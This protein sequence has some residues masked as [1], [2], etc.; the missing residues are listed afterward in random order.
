MS[1]EHGE[2]RPQIT[3][4][5]EDGT[6]F[7]YFAYCGRDYSPGETGWVLVLSGTPTPIDPQA[8]SALQVVE[9][10]ESMGVDTARDSVGF[11]TEQMVRAVEAGEVAPCRHDGEPDAPARLG[12][13]RRELATV[14]DRDV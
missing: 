4:L 6:R 5:G 9:D 13:L 1:D 3:V 12:Q 8:L 7:D 10:L 11:F 14:R 2:T